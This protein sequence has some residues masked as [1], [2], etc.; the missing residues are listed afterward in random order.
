MQVAQ[1]TEDDVGLYWLRN[2][3]DTAKAAAVLSALPPENGIAEVLWGPGLVAAGF[4]NPSKDDRTPDIILKLKPG[5]LIHD[6][7]KRAEHGGFSDDDT[8]V[9]LVLAGSVPAECWPAQA[10]KRR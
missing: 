7:L 2:Q 1:A 10:G 9:A 6:K 4:G 5:F 3:R 8:H